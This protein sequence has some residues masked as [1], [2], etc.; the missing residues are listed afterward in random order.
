LKKLLENELHT[1]KDVG[2]IPP[3]YRHILQKQGDLFSVVRKNN[4]DMDEVINAAAIASQKNK[5]NLKTLAGYLNNKN[6]AVQYWEPAGCADLQKQ[7]L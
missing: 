7:A 1:Q 3:Q 4:I 6:P 5:S 2:L